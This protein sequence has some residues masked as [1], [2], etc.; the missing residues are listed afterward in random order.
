M[1]AVAVFTLAWGWVFGKDFPPRRQPGED[2]AT[3]GS[4]C[5]DAGLC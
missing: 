4:N 2:R 1:L 3:Q 5:R